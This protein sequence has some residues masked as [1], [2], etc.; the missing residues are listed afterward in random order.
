MTPEL[1]LS[2]LLEIESDLSSA[3]GHENN[4]ARLRELLSRVHSIALEISHSNAENSS[5]VASW[6]Q[7]AYTVQA[8][9]AIAASFAEQEERLSQHR[10]DV[11]DT[12]KVLLRE[13]PCHTITGSLSGEG[14]ESQEICSYSECHQSKVAPAAA[15]HSE[16]SLNA[17]ILRRWMLKHMEHPFPKTQDKED[18]AEETNRGATS[19]K[20]QLRPEQVSGNCSQKMSNGGHR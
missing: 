13:Q 17:I 14:F 10:R 6:T 3:L 15:E 16:Q 11:T 1:A 2:Q 5:D 4:E 7:V 18:I 19:V 9:H 12:V 8:I 20:G